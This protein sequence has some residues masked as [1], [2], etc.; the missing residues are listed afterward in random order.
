MMK[1]WNPQ[2][3]MLDHWRGIAA[4]WVMLFHGFGTTY[5]EALSPL[6]EGL[7]AI[8]APGWLGVHLFFVISGYCITASVYNLRLKQGNTWDFLQN[9]FWRLFPIYWLALLATLIL[10]IISSPFNN[11]PIGNFISTSWQWWLG[12]ILLI[13]PY[14]GVSY[15][16]IVYWSLVVEIGF[17]LIVAILLFTESCTNTKT[18]VFIGLTL[19]VI[20]I[21][22]GG[23]GF[24]QIGALAAWSEFL[25]GALAFAALFAQSQNRVY[26]HYFAIGSILILGAVSLG[27]N[28]IGVGN[29]LW[30][31]VL[32]ALGLYLL[33][34][35]D[36]PL[37]DMKILHWLKFTGLMSYSLYLLHVPLQGRVIN[38]GSRFISEEDPL[39]LLLQVLGW[40]VAI[41]GS[42]LFYRFV[43]KPI[44]DWRYRRR[45]VSL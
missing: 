36:K 41:I 12:N 13:Q 24:T 15:Y 37:A 23:T 22:L 16:V 14:L 34:K 35:L 11:V 7:K 43:E 38:L 21:L 3:Q 1:I 40:A 39:F 17:Y 5:D 44:N 29:W 28:F 45:S 19:G 8:A 30:F 31:S 20:S 27:M 32:F 4:L 18:A 42:C 9:R 6:A 10:N 25:C 33:Y 2:Y 26:I